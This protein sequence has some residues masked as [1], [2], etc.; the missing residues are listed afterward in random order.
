[1]AG[2]SKT[3]A[4][5]PS[6][7]GLSTGGLSS[8]AG[9]FFGLA[10]DDDADGTVFKDVD[11]GPTQLFVIQEESAQAAITYI[12]LWDDK[13]PVIGTDAQDFQIPV[14]ASGNQYINLIYG[15]Y[16][17]NGL[18]W[19]CTTDKGTTANTSPGTPPDFWVQTSGGI[20]RDIGK[21]ITPTEVRGTGEAQTR[22]VSN[23][24]HSNEMLDEDADNNLRVGSSAACTLYAVYM[25]NRLNSEHAYL[26]IY[27]AASP[28]VGTDDP[29]VILRA[30]KGRELLIT[31]SK[32]I[33]LS[34]ALRYAVVTTGGTAGTTSPS[35][36]V[37][38]R[39]WY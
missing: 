7:V 25:D 28:T 23:E 31:F 18:S 38:L 33:S 20:W 32:G 35:D 34:T 15:G 6:S 2:V 27:D 17:L 14:A 3:L 29:D 1:M 10:F 12:Q 39:M 4:I 8:E 21:I 13:S 5:V 36:S 11:N 9:T 30:Y 16:F 22:T 37:I 26:K 24:R 19:A